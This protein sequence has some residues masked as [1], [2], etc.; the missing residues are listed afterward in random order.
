MIK[1]DFLR[2]LVANT[3]PIIQLGLNP[4]PVDVELDTLN[5]QADFKKQ[6]KI[7]KLMQCFD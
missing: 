2:D 1:L 6:L 3:M 7:L 4:I 5:I